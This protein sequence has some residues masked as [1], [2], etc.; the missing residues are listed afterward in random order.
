MSITQGIL[1]DFT[2]Y[3]KRDIKRFSA[4]LVH[5]GEKIAYN[6]KLFNNYRSR[7]EIQVQHVAF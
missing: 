2:R 5:F 3:L 1:K 6:L 7:M 4:I